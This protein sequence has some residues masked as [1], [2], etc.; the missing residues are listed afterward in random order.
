MEFVFWICV[1]GFGMWCAARNASKN[2]DTMNTLASVIS[3]FLR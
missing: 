2:Q 3:K 1:I